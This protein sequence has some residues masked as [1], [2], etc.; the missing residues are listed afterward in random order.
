MI[1]SEYLERMSQSNWKSQKE[2][3]ATN[4]NSEGYLESR[5]GIIKTL[6]SQY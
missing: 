3:I 2:E 5:F 6:D 1:P 4:D